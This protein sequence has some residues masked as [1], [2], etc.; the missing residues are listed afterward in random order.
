MPVVHSEDTSYKQRCY[1][2]A[3]YFSARWTYRQI[4]ADQNLSLGTVSN[5]CNAPA[6]PKK[7]KGRPFSID[8]AT[9]RQLV[10]TATS[11]AAHR[12]M[13]V[14][15]VAAICGVNACERT[16]LKAFAKE[17]YHRRVARKKPYLDDRKR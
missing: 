13:P 9:R 8:A 11:S 17:G 15:Q 10:F 3:L 7:R 5:I 1:V 12:R 6:T 2:Q 16:L 4:A 14:T